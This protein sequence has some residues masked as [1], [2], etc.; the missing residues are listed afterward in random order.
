MTAP[1]S[2]SPLPDT[3]VKKRPVKLIALLLMA[4]ASLALV[5]LQG[6]SMHASRQTQLHNANVATINMARALSDHADSSFDLVDA[7]LAGIAD[8]VKHD[9]ISGDGER[10]HRQLRSGVARAPLVD[11]V[12]IYDAAGVR[13]LSSALEPVV[14]QNGAQRDFFAYH[15]HQPDPR[16]HLGA[17]FLTRMG[18]V[19]MLPA[20]RRLERADGSFAGVAIAEVKL[21]IFRKYYES[22]QIGGKGVIVL[23]FDDGK[24]AVQHP[25]AKINSGSDIGDDFLFKLWH[26][27]GEAGSSTSDTAAGVDDDVVRLFSYR[28]LGRYP[29]LVSV[30]LSEDEVLETWRAGAYMSTVGVVLVLLVLLWMGV[31]LFRHVN[32]RDRLEA[33]L[34]TAQQGLVTKN[35]SLKLLARNDGLTGIANRRHF[36]ARLDAEFKRAAREGTSL[37][38]VFMDVDHFKKYNDHYGHPAG[39]TCLQFIAN[40]IRAGRRSSRNLAARVGG[41]EFAI[42]LPET[43]LYGAIAI[44]DSVRKAIAAARREHFGNPTG[45]VSVS[46]GVHALRPGEGGAS[47]KT[48]VESADLALYQAKSKGRNCVSPDAVEVALRAHRLPVSSP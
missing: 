15:R 10:L 25:F 39:D 34:R 26:K 11:A 48:L 37:A 30:A 6:W 19:W 4:F 24:L 42:L 14:P 20:S 33:Q 2:P 1:P 21:S 29:L 8:A 40:S 31:R 17:P 16:L 9:G 41:E 32:I 13:V 47:P 12:A 43:D 3:D 23:A 36:D 27:L 44:A 5:G 38:L 7:M 22:F 45:F 28:H 46:C 35:R 18:G